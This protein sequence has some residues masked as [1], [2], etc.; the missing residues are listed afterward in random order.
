MRLFLLYITGGEVVMAISVVLI[1]VQV[2]NTL[3]VQITSLCLL[4]LVISSP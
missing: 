3:P 1:E 2:I 4:A